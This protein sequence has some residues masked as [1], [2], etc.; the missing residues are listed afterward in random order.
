M[1]TASKTLNASAPRNWERPIA[2]SVKLQKFR[3]SR[4]LIYLAE[5]YNEGAMDLIT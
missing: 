4:I 1:S 3:S 5:Y 2:E